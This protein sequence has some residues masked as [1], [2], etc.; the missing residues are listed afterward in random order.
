MAKQ[1]NVD[2]AIIGAGTGG[3]Y[4]LRE[5]RRTKQSFV[6][7]DSGPLGTTCARVGCMPSKVA[8]H[9]AEYWNSQK[10]FEHYGISGAEHGDRG[11]DT[12]ADQLFLHDPYHA[13]D[14]IDGYGNYRICDADV[15]ESQRQTGRQRHRRSPDHSCGESGTKDVDVVFF[16]ILSPGFIGNRTC[17]WR[18]TQCGG[19]FLAS[20]AVA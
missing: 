8:L 18:V 6:L 13:G 10:E 17:P 1:I 5:V 16:C 7:I 4:A 19:K 12:S 9:I 11:A 3:M 2:V 20:V 15:C 14:C